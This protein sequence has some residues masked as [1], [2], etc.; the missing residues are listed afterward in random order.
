MS[1]TQI[2]PCAPLSESRT[3]PNDGAR[4]SLGRA[5]FR[6]QAAFVARRQRRA[7]LA[8]DDRM[9]ADIGLSR[10]DAYREAD[11]GFLDLPARHR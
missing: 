11:R 10:A 4:F 6:L 7:L 1:T 9:L 2:A 8:L 3:A 5:V